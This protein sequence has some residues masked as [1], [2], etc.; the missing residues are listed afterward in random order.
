MASAEKKK[1]IK[2]VA[3]Y[4]TP[5]DTIL[6]RV[7]A[8]LS[9]DIKNMSTENT[10]GLNPLIRAVV[11]KSGSGSESVVFTIVSSKESGDVVELA[12]SVAGSEAG[13]DL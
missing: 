13:V 1:M 6:L 5:R 12:D 4:V 7:L 9:V 8:P 10:Q 11:T 2:T 3:M